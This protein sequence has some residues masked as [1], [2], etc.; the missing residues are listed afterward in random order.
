MLF[1]CIQVI[2]YTIG[3]RLIVLLTTLMLRSPCKQSIRKLVLCIQSMDKMF[4]QSREGLTQAEKYNIGK[5][6]NLC[7]DRCTNKLNVGRVLVIA[8]TA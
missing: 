3:Y 5:H 4:K 7:S 6:T 2:T 8:I 1:H